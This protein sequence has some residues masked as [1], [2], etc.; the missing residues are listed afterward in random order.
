M[1]G[2]SLALHLDHIRQASA[3]AV[4]FEEGLTKSEFAS[5]KRT[6]QAVVMSLIII[7]ES[8]GKVMA[9]HPEFARAHSAVPWAAMRAMRNRMTHGYYDVDLDI[10]W[11]TVQT[12][13]PDL[14]ARLPSHAP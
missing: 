12:A 14:L 5:D 10:I 4:A 9:Q 8:A 3:D 1:I 2:R 6:Q 13:L 11:D 7:G